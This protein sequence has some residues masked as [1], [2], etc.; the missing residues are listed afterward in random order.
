MREGLRTRNASEWMRRMLLKM[1]V[2]SV[3]CTMRLS[4]R[5][6][7]RGWEGERDGS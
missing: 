7:E 1:R 4:G 3:V 6:K 5:M 2:G